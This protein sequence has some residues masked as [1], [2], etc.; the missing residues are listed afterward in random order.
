M[1]SSPDRSTV[2]KG[3]LVGLGTGT[4]LLALALFFLVALDRPEELLGV[5]LPLAAALVLLA[6]AT[7]ALVPLRYGD[8]RERSPRVIATVFRGLAVLGTVLT[9]AGVV[10]GEVPWIAAGLL[11]L[12]VVVGLVRDSQRVLSR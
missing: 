5:F 6:L 8:S 11:P 4:A 10:R 2:L 7:M 9:A 3:G 12:L 1:E